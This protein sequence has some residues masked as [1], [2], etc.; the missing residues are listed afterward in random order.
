MGGIRSDDLPDLAVSAL[1][2]GLDGIALRQLAGLVP[3]TLADLENLPES[4]FADMGLQPMNKEAAVDFLMGR[5]LP[6]TNAIMVLSWM[7][8]R[9]SRN[10]G[11]NTS[12]GGA[13][14][15]LD[16]ITTCLPSCILS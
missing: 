14:S 9:I 13:A 4:A 6:A 7:H 11:R 8:S 12:P 16:L 15:P 5:G 1:Q 10:D 3:P 2:Q